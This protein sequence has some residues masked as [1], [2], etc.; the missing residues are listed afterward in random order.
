MLMSEQ[1]QI[2]FV[3]NE[4]IK[5]TKIR[6]RELAQVIQAYENAISTLVVEQNPEV[7]KD[8]IAISLVDIADQS[9]GLTFA[10]NLPTLTMPAAFQI[11]DAIR[12]NRF[13]NINF[14]VRDDLRKIASFITK[15]GCHAYFTAQLD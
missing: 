8:V 10:P 1:L 12:L 15:R 4:N 6:S 9:I 13:E 14:R 7:A 2:R 5:P 3:G 11:A